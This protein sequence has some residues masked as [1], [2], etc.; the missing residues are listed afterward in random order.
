MLLG[1]KIMQSNRTL[2]I[3]VIVVLLLLLLCCC[4]LV[5]LGLGLGFFAFEQSSS[6][7]DLGG[8]QV[9]ATAI[10]QERFTVEGT[11]TLDVEYPVGDVV[12]AARQGAVVEIKAT[13]RAW[14]QSQATAE[15]W[16]EE[17]EL[18]LTQQDERIVVRVDIPEFGWR[19]EHPRVDLEI[20]VPSQT[21]L[22]L[23]LNVG[24][25]E[26]EGIEG[27]IDI[28]ANVG[29][30]ELRDV[31]ARHSLKVQTDVARIRF[32][33]AL[34]AGVRYEM[35]S[36]V[37]DIALWLPDDSSFEIDAQSDL[38][39]VSCDFDVKGEQERESYGERIK[40]TV[41]KAPTTE[42]KLESS[43]GS[44]EVNRD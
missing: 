11:P 2:W 37:G 17:I 20:A 35:R 38:G 18:A 43:V 27:Q 24:D 4:A 22:E 33:G 15:Q 12:I 34:S 31:I 30:V 5:I 8:S 1:G 26:V 32:R 9:E 14:A 41:G 10:V 23:R 39:S 6:V 3:I 13:K 21:D 36:E 28:Q 42:L 40:G 29:Q 19:G 44:I 7:S 16:L 25:V